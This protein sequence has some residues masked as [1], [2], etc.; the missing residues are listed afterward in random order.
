MNIYKL[1]K[2]IEFVKAIGFI[3]IQINKLIMK[4]YSHLQFIDISY[5]LKFPMPMCHRQFF[6]I[7]YQN[8]EYINYFCN[9]MENPFHF[10]CRKR[11]LDKKILY[12]CI[13][14]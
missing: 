2:E 9:D 10:A 12:N 6:R 14:F 11:Y 1:D 5:Y 13:Y 3:F 8:R 4:F 7:I